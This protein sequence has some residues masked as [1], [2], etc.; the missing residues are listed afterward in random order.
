MAPGGGGVGGAAGSTPADEPPTERV[1]FHY[2]YNRGKMR[3]TEVKEG[4]VCPF[5]LCE[6]K[7]F[8]CLPCHLE[9]SHDQF[10]FVFLPRV[11]GEDFPCVHVMCRNP[12]EARELYMHTLPRVQRD[13]SIKNASTRLVFI[14]CFLFFFVF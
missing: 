8:S 2:I 7:D 6:V 3:K 4:F 13:V 14:F 5:C 12:E 11:A 1:I 10:K 9:S